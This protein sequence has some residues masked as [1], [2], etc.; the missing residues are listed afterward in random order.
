M[1]EIDLTQSPGLGVCDRC[2]RILELG[3]LGC[4]QLCEECTLRLVDAIG[5][6]AIGRAIARVAE[7]VKQEKRHGD[8]EKGT[9]SAA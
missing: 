9:R 3:W 7:L 5:T 8:G 4:F 2:E 1:P 6:D